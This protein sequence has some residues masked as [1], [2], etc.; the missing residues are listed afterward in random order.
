VPVGADRDLGAVGEGV[1]LGPI[2]VA[3]DHV[4]PGNDGADFATVG[5]LDLNV[6]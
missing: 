4:E 2:P 3:I 5:G 1:G 6:L